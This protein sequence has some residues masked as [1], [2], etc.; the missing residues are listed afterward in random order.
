MTDIKNNDKD[1]VPCRAETESE[2]RCMSPEGVLCECAGD[3][4]LP[5]YMPE[6][7]KMLICT[8]RLVP[9]GKYIG[10]ERA[11]YSGSV[12]YSVVY[13]GEDGVP[14]YTTLTGDYEYSVPLGDAASSPRIEIFDEPVIESVS[15]RA[16][17]PRRISARARISAAP[18]VLYERESA[19]QSFSDEPDMHYQ[20]LTSQLS[21]VEQGHFESGEFTL[22][23]AFGIDASPDAE[24]VGCEGSAAVAEVSVAGDSV[25][26][27]GEVECRIIYY[28]IDRG[29]RRLMSEKKKFRFEREM[30][31]GTLRDI[32]GIR[33]YAKVISCD[34]S[35][36]EGVDMLCEM[37][38]C[39]SVDY[40]MSRGR[41]F[42]RD[43]YSCTHSTEAEYEKSSCRKDVLCKNANFSYHGQA[44]LPN[45]ISRDGFVYYCCPSVKIGE[46]GVS[47]AGAS[48]CGDITVECLVGC[49]AD[50]ECEYAVCPIRIPFRCEMPVSNLAEKY[51]MRAHADVLGVRV[52]VDGENVMADAELYLSM[53]VTGEDFIRCVSSIESSGECEPRAQDEIL[54]YYPDKDET[55]WSVSKKYR[56]ALSTVAKTNGLSENSPDDPSSLDGAGPLIIV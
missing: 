55:L 45:N 20:T 53:F 39:I 28:D 16:S 49:D 38:L 17:G 11:E 36:T 30:S 51:E 56:A 13:T 54:V 48:V 4:T 29:R 31:L 33:A 18:S 43:I 3:F 6:I 32:V 35:R 9:A 46:C 5:D 26:C 50:G 25:R 44:Q 12:V 15:A 2:M 1:F 52:R 37:S 47:E 42:L 34:I 27:R 21:S 8:P 23:E 19:L 40:A 10:S 24:F 41:E 7:A 14:F 22:E